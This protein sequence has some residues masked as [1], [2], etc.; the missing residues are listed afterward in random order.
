M[1]TGFELLNITSVFTCTTVWLRR[2]IKTVK[3]QRKKKTRNIFS[4]NTVRL[5]RSEDKFTSKKKK[6][7]Y[8]YPLW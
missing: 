6:K 4:K 3:I 1:P 2:H 5:D 7:K 8:K